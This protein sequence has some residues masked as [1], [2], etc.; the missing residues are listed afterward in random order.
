MQEVNGKAGNWTVGGLQ[1]CAPISFPV[2]LP[3][4]EEKV[5]H[6]NDSDLGRT[7]GRGYRQKQGKCGKVLGVVSGESGKVTKGQMRNGSEIWPLTW[8]RWIT[9]EGS[10]LHWRK[11]PLA[12]VEIM[13][14]SGSNWSQEDQR[15]G[16]CY[17]NP[18]KSW[19]PPEWKWQQEERK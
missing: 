11:V 14:Y 4:A 12:T 8:K 19:R 7:S 3:R 9:A 18:T 13:N 5:I 17:S 6:E 16:S 1:S 2:L 15:E 10:E